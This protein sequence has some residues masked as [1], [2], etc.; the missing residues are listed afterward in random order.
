MIAYFIN[1]YPKVSH[2]FIRREILALEAA[3]YRVFRH[4]LRGW[5]SQLADSTDNAERDKT[6]FLL[7]GGILPVV[8]AP[9]PLLFRRPRAMLRALALS[10]RMM[11]RSD[12]SVAMHLFT[13]C[14]AALLAHRLLEQG[15]RHLH[16]HFGTNSAEIAMLAGAMADIPFSFTVH[17]PDEF[18]GP[19]FMKLGLKVARARFVAAITPFCAS[20]IY[21]WS[22]P[23]DWPKIAVVRCGLPARYFEELPTTPADAPA[24]VC[25]ARLSPQ[26]GLLLLLEAV[27]ELARKGRRVRLTLVGDGELRGQIEAAIARFGLGEDVRITGWASEEAVRSYLRDARALV[28]PSFAEG[29]PIVI[30]EA[31]ALGRPVLASNVGAVS[32]LVVDGQTGWLFPPGSVDEIVAAIEACLDTDTDA[33]RAMGAAAR[34]RVRLR[35]NAEVEA[36]KLA[37]L[38]SGGMMAKVAA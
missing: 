28:L 31:M 29:L 4:A 6:R 32:E 18:D 9:L 30:M 15:V 14:E 19:A 37:A 13:Y 16:A 38:I 12:R 8:F 7:R 20:Q 26:K 35:Q 17:G 23:E 5:S 11:P 3:G 33:L 22:D 21:R 27:H 24:F 2:S 34:E 25:V 1:E 36:A 10:L